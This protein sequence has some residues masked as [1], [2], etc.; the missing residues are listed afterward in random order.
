[1]TD[2]LADRL[3]PVRAGP[4]IEQYRGDAGVVDLHRPFQG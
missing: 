4:G 1:M 2:G 3:T